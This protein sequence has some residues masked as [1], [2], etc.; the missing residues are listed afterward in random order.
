MLNSKCTNTHLRLRLQIAIFQQLSENRGLCRESSRLTDSRAQLAQSSRVKNKK[1]PIIFIC[2]SFGGVVVKK[3]LILAHAAPESSDESHLFKS[4]YGI[5]FLATPH[6][7]F[8]FSTS[9]AIKSPFRSDPLKELKAGS[10][11]LELMLFEFKHIGASL[12]KIVSFYESNG[13]ISSSILPLLTVGMKVVTK[14]SA[15]TNLPNEIALPLDETHADMPKFSNIDSPSFLIVVGTLQTMVEGAVK[16]HARAALPVIK[17]E[18]GNELSTTPVKLPYGNTERR[19]HKFAGSILSSVLSR[20][21]TIL[22]LQLRISLGLFEK[23]AS[24]NSKLGLRILIGIGQKT[25]EDVIRRQ[26]WEKGAAKM[27]DAAVAGSQ[28]L[29]DHGKADLSRELLSQ[30]IAIFHH[31]L[32]KDKRIEVKAMVDG[33]IAMYLT[34][35]ANDNRE[36]AIIMAELWVEEWQ[37]AFDSK[38]YYAVQYMVNALA[39]RWFDAMESGK[40]EEAY[41]INEAAMLALDKA[42]DSERNYVVEYLAQSMVWMWQKSF[43]HKFENTTDTFADRMKPYLDRIVDRMESEEQG[44]QYLWRFWAELCLAA[45]KCGTE[46]VLDALKSIAMEKLKTVEKTEYDAKRQVAQVI[47]RLVGKKSCGL[48][49]SLRFGKPI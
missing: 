46:D 40:Q 4:V 22:E 17:P 8:T 24:L 31:Y 1:R 21:S 7:G 39:Q 5:I 41:L 2:H 23:C 13:Q 18:L 37:R 12:E 44:F 32:E 35:I 49:P 38:L 29:I 48:E 16:W 20:N 19:L 34:A 45:I 33:A 27:S 3:A 42:I 25:Y 14:E 10:K 6:Q 36:V 15:L 26:W 43:D 9:A 11:S 30:C 47:G 28:I